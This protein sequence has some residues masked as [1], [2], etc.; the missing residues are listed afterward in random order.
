MCAWKGTPV[1]EVHSWVSQLFEKL[2]LV[3]DCSDQK[4]MSSL[5][6]PCH[7][8]PWPFLI[9]TM[10]KNIKSQHNC[11]CV[12]SRVYSPVAASGR[13]TPPQCRF[14]HLIYSHDPHHFSS[15]PLFPFFSFL[16]L[17]LSCIYTA[18]FRLSLLTIY[19]EGRAG[20]SFVEWV[21]FKRFK[22]DPYVT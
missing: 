5:S 14:F 7:F 3:Q 13:T 6:F 19:Q 4:K 16:F 22:D 20:P 2:G 8:H 17:Q 11:T 12:N 9:Q 10:H 21:I 15:S 18:T 1:L